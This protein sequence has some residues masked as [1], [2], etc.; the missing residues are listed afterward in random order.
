MHTQ[1]DHARYPFQLV[2]KDI[3]LAHD[4]WTLAQYSV[5]STDSASSAEPV[6]IYVRALVHLL[7]HQ[8][9]FINLQRYV[10][11]DS[12]GTSNALQT[13]SPLAAVESVE[14]LRD[15]VLNNSSLSFTSNDSFRVWEVRGCMQ[16]GLSCLT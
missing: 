12:K 6:V 15:G 5:I 14:S 1:V 8:G 9:R 16:L 2:Y 13:L 4:D 3:D 7:V 10:W 11:N